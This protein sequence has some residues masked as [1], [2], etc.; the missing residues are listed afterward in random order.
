M[1][2]PETAERN[3]DRARQVLSHRVAQLREDRGWRPELLAGLAGVSLTVVHNA[4]SGKQ[5]VYFENIVRLAAAFD[6]PLCDLL[7]GL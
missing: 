6:V 7:E 1:Q 4:E 2:T 3:A 5:R